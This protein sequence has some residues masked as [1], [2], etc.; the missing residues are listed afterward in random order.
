MENQA[1]SKCLLVTGN[2]DFSRALSL[3]DLSCFY[4]AEMPS[5][6][7]KEIIFVS[8]FWGKNYNGRKGWE[9]AF[10]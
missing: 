5:L 8:R 10:L 3:K 9:M 1:S 4:T 7:H 6:I 2:E